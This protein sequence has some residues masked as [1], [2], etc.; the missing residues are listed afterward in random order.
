MKVLDTN[1]LTHLFEGHPRVVQRFEQETEEVATTIITRIE[2][3]DAAS[4]FLIPGFFN[5]RFCR[6]VQATNERP[7][8]LGPVLRRQRE[9]LS[10]QIICFLSHD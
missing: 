4:N 7:G 2:I 5:A 3:L 1:T 10:Q 8:Q 6:C 9:R